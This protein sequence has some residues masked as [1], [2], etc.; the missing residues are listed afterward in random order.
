MEENVCIDCQFYENC[1][2]PYKV[3]KCLGYRNKTRHDSEE[4][5]GKRAH[6]IS[7]E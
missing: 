3:M 6:H 5:P 1:K 4:L 2:R 7:E